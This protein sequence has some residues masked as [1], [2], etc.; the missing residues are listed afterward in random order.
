VPK[1]PRTLNDSD[2]RWVNDLSYH[3]TWNARTEKMA[4]FIPRN[5]KSLLELGAGMCHLK[6]L[7]PP[8]ISYTPSDIIDRGD[9]SIIMDFNE[10]EW[11]ITESYDVVFASGVFEYVIE[12]EK[13]IEYLG[14]I[15]NTIICSYA[16]MN[17]ID[18]D[19]LQLNGWKNNFTQ[20]EFQKLFKDT[21]FYVDGRKS[22][23]GGR[24]H[25]L[26]RFIK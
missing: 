2:E 11:C 12:L 17:D 13:F 26:Y 25:Y 6:T 4:T 1:H 10:D 14:T 21:D 24:G 9:G 19:T 7:L 20:Q 18:S 5:T 3:E 16:L 8:T 22:W 23:Q 15:T